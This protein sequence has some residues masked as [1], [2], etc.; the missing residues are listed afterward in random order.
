MGSPL[1]ASRLQSKVCEIWFSGGVG[2]SWSSFPWTLQLADSSDFRAH[3]IQWSKPPLAA[4]FFCLPDLELSLTLF[5]GTSR[6]FPNFETSILLTFNGPLPAEVTSIQ[7]VLCD[8]QVSCDIVLEAAL[9]A[10]S[11]IAWAWPVPADAIRGADFFI[12]ALFV[13]RVQELGA[14][15]LFSI[16]GPWFFCSLSFVHFSGFEESH[17]AREQ[18]MEIDPDTCVFSNGFPDTISNVSIPRYLFSGFSSSLHWQ[19]HCNPA[20]TEVQFLAQN[21]TVQQGSPPTTIT[22]C[23]PSS[24]PECSSER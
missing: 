5:G 17:L 14:S 12:R 3:G 2:C 1:Q 22:L 23:V 4:L 10:A 18:G 6:V 7:L 8:Q 21:L 16:Q 9:P 15:S 20:V 19:F 24:S 11:T 13:P